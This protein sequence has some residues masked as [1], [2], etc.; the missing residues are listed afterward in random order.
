MSGPFQISSMKCIDNQ[1]II[2]TTIGTVGIVDARNHQVIKILRCHQSEVFHLLPLPLQ[3]ASAVCAEMPFTNQNINV[4]KEEKTTMQSH[5]R[6]FELDMIATVGT[7]RHDCVFNSHQVVAA[8][9]AGTLQSNETLL[10]L[11]KIEN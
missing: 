11:W 10:Q 9:Q 3:L 6:S 4:A 7:G 5:Y 8:D 1:I 2:G